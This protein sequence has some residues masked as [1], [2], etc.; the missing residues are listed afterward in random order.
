VVSTA[1]ESSNPDIAEANARG[2]PV[3]HRS[4][5]L[6]AIVD[7]KRT[8]AVAG[9]SGK[10]T[11]TAMIFDFLDHCGMSP[12]V[13]TGAGLSSLIDRGFIGNARVGKSDLL[14]IEADES[15]GTLVRYHPHLSLFLN[16]SKDHKPVAETQA[17]FRTLAAQSAHV[18]KNAESEE[19]AELL[20]ERT[21]GFGPSAMCRPDK[22]TPRGFSTRVTW[23]GTTFELR[24]PGAF[25]VANVMAA[26]CVAE[27]L[28]CEPSALAK[29]AASYR[30]I[31]RRFS[32]YPTLRGVSVV[33]DY[34]HNPE[35]I[36]AALTTA[37]L[38]TP[39]VLAIFQPHGF[40]PTRFLKDDLVETFAAVVRPKDEL[41]LLPIY[42][43]GGTADKSISS[44]D[45]A[46]P[47]AGRIAVST[48]ASRPE[49]LDAL[50]QKARKGD[51]VI[52]MGARDPSL[53]ALARQ[54]VQALGGL[55]TP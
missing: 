45:I 32:V 48:P 36:R 1:I 7:T 39:R 23:R 13:I 16:V 26:F 54:I 19:L 30:G 2:L 31:Y 12:S 18:M 20:A 9:T 29:A 33:D 47:L 22:V 34:A 40:G 4:E 27:S 43:A 8:I 50:A 55:V 17:M 46:A 5:V 35:K 3:F 21:F 11:V 28:G 10:S 41:F 42:Y 38:L 44:G 15:D 49:L 25:N 6:A 52:L 24:L 14:V 37:Q 51:C 53:E